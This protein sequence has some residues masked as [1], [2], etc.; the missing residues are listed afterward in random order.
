MKPNLILGKQGFAVL[1]MIIVM[2]VALAA[3]GGDSG[4]SSSGS[5]GN[6]NANANLSNADLLKKA[7]TDMKALKSYNVDASA[8]A[9]GMQVSFNANLDLT[10]KKTSV[11]MNA[12]GI[13]AQAVIIGSTAYV[14]TDGGK[15]FKKND[16]AST[17]ASFDTFTK[18]WD[19]F[20]P[21]E[22]D[23]VK[24]AL[25]DASPATDTIDGVSTKHM[26]GS[27]KDLA[28]LA[29]STGEQMD[30]GTIDLWV[31]TDENP[32]VRQMK[33]VGKSSGQDVNATLKWSKI[34]ENFDI[35]APTT[36]GEVQAPII[37][38]SLIK[39]RQ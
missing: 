15:T 16:A 26:T 30:N 29:S 2:S 27:A 21:T 33:V 12:M 4:A 7:A 37:S 3:C 31:T 38:A 6:P 22:V 25:K 28:A 19:N 13:D 10:N 8:N 24:D 14:S 35:Q 11:K 34:N 9:A 17:T 20:S 39:P 1:L 36:T 18:L 23:K 32:T 5:V